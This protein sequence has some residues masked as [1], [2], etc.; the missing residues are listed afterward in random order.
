MPDSMGKPPKEKCRDALT[1]LN[2]E[3]C[4]CVC[5]C[6]LFT[7]S[8]LINVDISMPP[9]MRKRGRPKGAEV[10]VIVLPSKKSKKGAAKNLPKKPRVVPF[11]K[12]HSSVKERGKTY[13]GQK[14]SCALL[15]CTTHTAI[16][17]FCHGLLTKK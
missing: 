9:M 8:M 15:T 3:Y 12:L 13:Y 16:Q 10:T 5:Q 4:T 2:S 1:D 7:P 17:R 11:L 14:C 6:A